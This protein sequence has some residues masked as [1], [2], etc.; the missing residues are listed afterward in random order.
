VNKT[1]TTGQFVELLVSTFVSDMME[2]ANDAACAA[3][4]K[5][6]QEK[7]IDAITYEIGEIV[8]AILGIE[9]DSYFDCAQV[10]PNGYLWL[11]RSNGKGGRLGVDFGPYGV[12]QHGGPHIDVYDNW[13]QKLG[14]SRAMLFA[15]GVMEGLESTI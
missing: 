14:A 3:A 4:E 5:W 12:G 9:A 8:G 2:A 15:Q 11:G 13:V 6:G 1:D 7:V 10:D